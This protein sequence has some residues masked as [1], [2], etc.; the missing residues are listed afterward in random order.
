MAILGIGNDIIEIERIRKSVARY[1]L[2]LINR[3]FTMN[4]QD[5]CLKYKDPIPRFAVRFAAKEAIVKALGTGFGEHVGWLD[6]AVIN[7]A[8]GRPEVLFSEVVLERFNNPDIL[9]SLSH[10]D[11]YASAIAIWQSSCDCQ[12]SH[13][14]SAAQRKP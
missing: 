10:S 5:Y 4:E 3:L 8:Q 11:Q 6:L 7:N 12:R 14:T 9:I 1:G 13:E 2:R